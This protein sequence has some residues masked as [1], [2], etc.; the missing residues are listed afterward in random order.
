MSDLFLKRGISKFKSDVEEGYYD[1]AWQ[2]KA[3]KAMQDRRE[4]KFDDYLKQH[5][6][7]VFGDGTASQQSTSKEDVNDGFAEKDRDQTIRADPSGLVLDAE[8]EE[9]GESGASSDGEWV[10]NKTDFRKTKR[11]ASK[12]VAN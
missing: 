3:R 12:L 7:E 6:E 5:V 8:G 9:D 11:G 10:E 2:T 1:L 4:G